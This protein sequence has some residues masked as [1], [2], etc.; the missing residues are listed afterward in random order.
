MRAGKKARRSDLVDIGVLLDAYYDKKPDVNLAAQAVIFGTSGHRGNANKNSFN[1]NHILAIAQAI[2]DIRKKL[3]ITGPCF[4]GKDTHLLSSPALKTLLEV[5]VANQIVAVIAENDGYTPTPVISHAIINYNRNRTDQF[6]D[7]IVITPSHNQPE[8]GGIK[9]NSIYGEPADMNITKA[10]ETRANMLLKDDISHVKHVPYS[11]ALHSGYICTT[12]YEKAYIDDLVNVIDMNTIAGADLNI[13]IDPL[14]GAGF[15]YWPII[16]EKYKLN[17]N[18]VN[19]TLDPTFGFMHLDHDGI[20]RMDCSSP[21]AMNGLIKLKDSFDLAF[22]N[23]TDFDRHGIVTPEG[24]MNANAYLATVTDYLLVHRPHWKPDIAIGK[25]LVTT[26]MLDK[27]A[28]K[29]GHK[30]CEYPVGFKWYAQGLFRGKLGFACEESAGGSFLRHN[31]DVW[32]T[33]KDGIILCLL[34][35]EM[36]AKTNVNP[37]DRYKQLTERFGSFHYGRIQTKASLAE[38]E[39]LAELDTNKLT[40]RVFSGEKI[41]QS[42]TKA[43]ANNMPIGGLKV[44]IENGWFAARSSGTED[45]YKIYAESFISDAHLKQIQQEAQKV[46]SSVIK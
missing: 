10:I 31:G 37:A 22:C 23:D 15:T 20:I 25:T 12:C 26:A 16:A 28:I 27:I 13:G 43:P 19:D 29:R 32:T 2:V 4:I 11:K 45:A 30:C 36:T 38:R 18:I 5:F 9:Y 6:A 44:I 33:D 35:A 24:L 34:A 17:L 3:N 21:F 46:V 1:E 14:G 41:E 40:T 39:K 42:L 7:G 8:D